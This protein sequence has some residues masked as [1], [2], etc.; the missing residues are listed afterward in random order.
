MLTPR[1]T[2]HDGRRA[3]R[4]AGWKTRAAEAEG[5]PRLAAFAAMLERARDL[6]R[7]SLQLIREARDGRRADERARAIEAASG[8][9]SRLM[10][11]LVLCYLPALFLLVVIPL[12]IGLVDGLFGG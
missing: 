7:G 1:A 3:V 2:N 10:L 11:V 4:R 5:L 9:E 8:V 12:F 6:G